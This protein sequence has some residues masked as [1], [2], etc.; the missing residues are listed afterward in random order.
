ME[1]ATTSA[2]D[3]VEGVIR[4]VREVESSDPDMHRSVIKAARFGM[5]GQIN[6]PNVLQSH[7]SLTS[8]S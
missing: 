7:P 3:D 5:T 4:G 6:I 8:L 2:F 1:V